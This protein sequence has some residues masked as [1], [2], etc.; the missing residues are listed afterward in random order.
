MY[1]DLKVLYLRWNIAANICN[2]SHPIF[3]ICENILIEQISIY[4]LVPSRVTYLFFFCNQEIFNFLSTEILTQSKS[5]FGCNLKFRTFNEF[6]LVE[7]FKALFNNICLFFIWMSVCRY[8]WQLCRYISDGCIG[9]RVVS[10]VVTRQPLHW[11]QTAP[12]RK[13]WRPFVAGNWLNAQPKQ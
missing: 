4:F 11:L 10:R 12:L 7:M 3:F 5:M 1:T 9:W 2:T 8:S 13:P 6:W